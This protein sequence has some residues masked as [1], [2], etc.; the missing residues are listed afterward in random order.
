MVREMVTVQVGQCG[1]QIGRR[2]WAELL[3]EAAAQQQASGGAGGGTYDAAM[4]AFFR[5]VDA[6]YEPPAELAVGAPLSSLRA[7]ALLIDTE[8]GVVSETL[9]DPRFGDLFDAAQLVTD[10]SGAGNNWGHG[11]GE[12]GPKYGDEIEAAVRRRERC[13]SPQAFFFLHSVGGGT[14]SGLG[15]AVL[16]RFVDAFPDLCRFSV[17]VYPGGDDEDVV[18][19][20]YNAVLATQRLTACADCVVPLENQALLDVCARRSARGAQA[21]ASGRTATAAKASKSGFD[22][23]NDVAAQLLSHLTAGARYSGGLNIDVNEIATNLVPF[24]RLHYLTASYAPLLPRDF[25][26]GAAAALIGGGG[27][28]APR[29]LRLPPWNPDG[30]KVG[31]CAVPPLRAS[32]AVL[33]LANSTAIARNFSALRDRFVKLYRAKAM[34]H[35]Y[36]NYIDGAL[37]DEA[38][39][40]LEALVGDYE[41]AEQRPAALYAPPPAPPPD[42]GTSDATPSRRRRPRCCSKV[43]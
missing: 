6:R 23:T 36:A 13:D 12:Y 18:T 31:L 37:F 20:P 9:R 41:L 43:A 8:E 42:D 26:G 16:E 35:H 3:H 14:G 22:E 28:A 33:C 29:H 5:N 21:P 2:F 7:R 32:R 17:A 11:Y 39:A 30:F 1:N 25:G 24:P 19:A 40:D 34:V 38:L 15:S 4:S 10:V 27:D